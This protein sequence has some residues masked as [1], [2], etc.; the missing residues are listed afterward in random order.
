MI[1]NFSDY[2]SLF[3]KINQLSKLNID[4]YV[5][6]GAALLYREIKP[7]T[8]DIDIVVNT[9]EEFDELTRALKILNFRDFSPQITGYDNFNLAKKLKNEDMHIDIFLKEICSKFSF[10]KEMVKRSEKIISLDKIK[11]YLS[12]NEDIF[13][14]KTMTERPGDLDD[15]ISLAQ[16]GLDWN[17]ILIEMKSQIKNSG[18]DIWIT[19][20]NE[21]LIDI[22]EKGIVIP[23]LDQTN[24]LAITYNESLDVK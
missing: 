11:I 3:N 15:C 1:E 8:K 22:E 13:S 21:R 5:I 4:I 18:K 23:I 14:F 24:K 9:R 12:S 6:G 19:W 2:E 7:S 17:V 10:S 16:R 20:I